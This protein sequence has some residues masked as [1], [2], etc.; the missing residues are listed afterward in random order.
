MNQVE[1]I[2]RTEDIQ[3]MYSV[4]RSLSQRDYLLFKFAIH[5]GIKLSEL[6]NMSVQRLKSIENGNI[7]TTWI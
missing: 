6:L 7:K 3:K 2:R 5:T 1:P 4:L